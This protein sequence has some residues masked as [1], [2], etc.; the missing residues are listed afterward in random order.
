M[1]CIFTQVFLGQRL[2][3][4]DIID[5][6]KRAKPR[7]HVCEFLAQVLAVAPIERSG[8][9]PDFLDKPEERLRRASA[10]SVAS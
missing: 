7:Q 4:I 8:Q 10:R 2:G 3:Q 5:I 9:F 6:R 1:R